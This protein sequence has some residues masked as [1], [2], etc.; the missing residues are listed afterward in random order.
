[1]TGSGDIGFALVAGTEDLTDVTVRTR[2]RLTET[3]PGE[4]A[5]STSGRRSGAI[6]VAAT[7]TS[8]G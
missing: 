7:I 3:S 4:A 5:S 2:F 1:M 8:V 6:P